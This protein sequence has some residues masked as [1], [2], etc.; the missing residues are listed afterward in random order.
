MTMTWAYC[1]CGQPL[2]EPSVEEVCNG[3][4]S[5]PSCGKESPAGKDL[6][7]LLVELVGRIEELERRPGCADANLND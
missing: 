1:D 4:R 5:C 2:G 6:A 3:T 7:E